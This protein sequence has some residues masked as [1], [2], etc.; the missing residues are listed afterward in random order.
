MD[1]TS[2]TDGSGL[3]GGFA[4][5]GGLVAAWLY[6]R[7]QLS[8]DRVEMTADKSE[9]KQLGRLETEIAR[10]TAELEKA[11][12]KVSGF[13][14]QRTADA[15]RIAALESEAAYLTRE[16]DKLTKD[17]RKAVRSLPPAARA[18]LET[19]FSA[20]GDVEERVDVRR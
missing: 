3:L 12:N 11:T 8:R 15:R 19:N 18:V 2:I 7:R 13:E 20:L 5:L 6:V 10:L 14:A 16:R 9:Q 1:P 4:G 17:I